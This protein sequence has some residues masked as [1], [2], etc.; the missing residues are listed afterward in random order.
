MKIGFIGLGRMG[1]AMAA[2]LLNAGHDVTVFNRSPQKRRAL[3]ALGA[4]EAGSV[5]DACHGELVVTMLADDIAVADVAFANGGIV[6]TLAKGAIHLSMSTIS[7]TLSKKLTETHAHAGQ[8]FVAAPVFGRPDAAAAAKLF[9]V[10]AGDSAT[11]EACRSLFDALGSKTFTVGAEPAAANL[12]KLSGN[13]LTA[14]AI[15]A[16]GEAIALVGKAGIDPS[17]Y[18]ELLT[19]TI[20]PA[21]AYKTYGRLIAANNFQPAAFAAPLGFKDIRLM[22]AAAESLRVP[23]PLGSLLHDRFLRLLADGGDSLDWA[24][25]GGLAGQDAGL[26]RAAPPVA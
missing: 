9:I 24:A 1:S 21:P 3:L 6:G 26:S 10:A 23:M 12:V 22:L 18:V 25:I 19:S 11:L 16:L 4:H 5:A 14:A 7:V 17:V 2:N 13:F 8:R 20:F 15:E